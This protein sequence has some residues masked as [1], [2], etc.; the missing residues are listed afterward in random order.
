M[1]TNQKEKFEWDMKAWKTKVAK[2]V[3]IHKTPWHG[4][5]YWTLS[6]FNGE[7]ITDD[8]LHTIEFFKFCGIP[9]PECYIDP[10]LLAEYIK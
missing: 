9:W 8:N 4:G 5:W 6:I 2:L 1:S 3:R 7:E 10:K